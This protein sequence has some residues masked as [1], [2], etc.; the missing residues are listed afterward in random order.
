MTLEMKNT[1]TC[2]TVHVLAHVRGCVGGGGSWR[3]GRA[4]RPAALY[5]L[6]DGLSTRRS[7]A[8]VPRC[9]SIQRVPIGCSSGSNIRLCCTCPILQHCAARETLLTPCNRPCPH[10]TG[11]KALFGQHRLC[12]AGPHLHCH[13]NIQHTTATVQPATTLAACSAGTTQPGQACQPHCTRKQDSMR[14]RS[15]LCRHVRYAGGKGDV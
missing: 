2:T 13:D 3:E 8:S 9:P 12:Q 11:C 10:K 7:G 6:Q 1:W 4:C 15:R 5:H 14:Q